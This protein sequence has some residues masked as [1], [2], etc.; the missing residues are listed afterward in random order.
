MTITITITYICPGQCLKQKLLGGLPFK[1]NK[2]IIQIERNAI[3]N[4]NWQEADQLVIYKLGR[5]VEHGTTE[6]QLQLVVGRLGT[7]HLRLRCLLPR[8]VGT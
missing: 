4:P 1:L 6:E 3:E 2:Q 8:I 5:G 7:R